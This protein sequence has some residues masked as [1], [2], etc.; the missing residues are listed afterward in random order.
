MKKGQWV[1]L[2]VSTKQLKGYVGKL[3]E[4]EPEKVTVQMVSVPSH[5]V[6]WEFASN[7]VH[8]AP[9]RLRLST[10]WLLI[11]QGWKACSSARKTTIK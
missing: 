7:L 10:I 11:S 9:L 4:I 2:K 8:P 5:G 6:V 3:L 1:I